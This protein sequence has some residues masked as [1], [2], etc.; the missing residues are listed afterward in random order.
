MEVPKGKTIVVRLLV[1]NLCHS[2][3]IEPALCLLPNT[4]DLAN[5][6]LFQGA[7]VNKAIEL[8]RYVHALAGELVLGTITRSAGL[9][10]N[11]NRLLRSLN[12]LLRLRLR[13]GR[14]ITDL[15]EEVS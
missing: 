9:I 15:K 1:A 12:R 3:L 7:G 13:G 14:N 11:N 6:F 8:G 2:H 4:V 5:T 10:R